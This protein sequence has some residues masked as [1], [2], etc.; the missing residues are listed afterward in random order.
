[1][2]QSAGLLL[3]RV[4]QAGLFV[5]VVHPSGPYNAKAA[6]GLPK[7]EPDGFETLEMTARREVLEEV[8]VVIPGP[9]HPLG[10][11]DYQKS[12]KRVTAFAA[13]LPLDQVPRCASWEIDRCEL[14]PVDAARKVLHVDQVAFLDR[15][16]KYL[17]L[18]ATP[19]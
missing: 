13:E 11:V 18:R 12:K 14:V 6:W 19:G 17:A 8:G 3:Y 2:K 15:L 16:I 5:V 4:T 1:M 9:V 7:G 10:F